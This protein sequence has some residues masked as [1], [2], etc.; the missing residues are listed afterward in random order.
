M[1]IE[2]EKKEKARN[3]ERLTRLKTEDWTKVETPLKAMIT[4]ILGCD[5]HP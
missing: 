1:K 5:L 2:Q 3:F 4:W